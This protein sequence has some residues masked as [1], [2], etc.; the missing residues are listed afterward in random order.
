MTIE[1]AIRH[2]GGMGRFQWRMVFIYQMLASTGSFSLYTMMYYELIPTYM[3]LG[4]SD[5]PAEWVKC[6]R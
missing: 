4:M 6:T 1:D 5:N 3:C 2:A